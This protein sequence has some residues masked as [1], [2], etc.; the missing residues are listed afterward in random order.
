VTN[1]SIV[2][3][4]VKGNIVSSLLVGQRIGFT[5]RHAVPQGMQNK[6]RLWVKHA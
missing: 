2:S 6:Q 3:A 5:I 1:R 4:M